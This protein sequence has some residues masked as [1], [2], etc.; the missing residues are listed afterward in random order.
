MGSCAGSE[1]LL[2]E[3]E[4]PERR[5]PAKKAARRLESGGEALRLRLPLLRAVVERALGR[6]LLR[7]ELARLLAALDG[8]PLEELRAVLV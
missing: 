8:L 7:L 1:A 6:A 3:R 5:R 4:P 2:L